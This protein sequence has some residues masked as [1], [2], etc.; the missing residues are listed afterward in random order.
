[1]R[2]SAEGREQCTLCIYVVHILYLCIT[3]ITGMCSPG[4]CNTG[5]SED[6]ILKLKISI[7]F[8]QWLSYRL[9]RFIKILSARDHL[10]RNKGQLSRMMHFTVFKASCTRGVP[11]GDIPRR[12]VR[13]EPWELPG[14][15]L[16]HMLW[17]MPQ[18]TSLGCLLYNSDCLGWKEMQRRI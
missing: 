1:M 11:A 6:S 3:L 13:Q 18:T 9:L 12:C 4:L 15:Q 2:Q 17:Q 10:L 8:Q 7:S 14:Q 5:W 16:H